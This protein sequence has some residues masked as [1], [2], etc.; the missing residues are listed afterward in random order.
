MFK[1]LILHSSKGRATNEVDYLL[2]K[3]TLDKFP[4]IKRMDMGDSRL[5][6]EGDYYRKV[7]RAIYEADALIIENTVSSFR[8]GHEATL[9][10]QQ[11]KPTLVLNKTDGKNL[12][13]INLPHFFESSYSRLNLQELLSKFLKR[14][15]KDILSERLNL[16]VSNSQSR[17]L[18]QTSQREHKSKSAIIRDLIETHLHA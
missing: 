2:L 15:K 12:N 13:P 4:G 3:T 9:A 18:Q 16:F 17:L 8:L 11:G 5:D 10:A 7:K 1:V 6:K 14:A